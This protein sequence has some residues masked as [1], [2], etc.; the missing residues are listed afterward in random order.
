[1]EAAGP[2]APPV[3]AIMV[4]HQ[5]G[6]WFDDVLDALARQD[7]SNLKVLVLLVGETLDIPAR[8]RDRVPNSFVRAVG[9]NP[10]FGAA[11]NEVLRLVEGDN[12]FFCFLHDDVALD[13]GAIRLL[14]EELYRSNAGVVGPKLVSWDDPRILQHVGLAVDRL[15]EVDPI[16][17]PGEYDQEQHDAVRDVF[18]LPTACLLV[19]ADLFRSIGGFDPVI[20]YQGDDVD[21]CWRAHL[22]GARVMVVPAARG[23]HVEAL[24]IRRP[25]LAVAGPAARNR[26]RTVA[27]LTGAGRLPLIL[28]QL[29]LMTIFHA[30]FDLVRGR[31]RHAVASLVALVGMVPSAPAAL[32]RRRS[33]A[34]IRHVP[35]REVAGLQ[36]R[37]SARVATYLRARDS[38]PEDPEVGNERSWR[39]SAGS[40]PVVVWGLVVLLFLVGSRRVITGGVPRFGEFLPF[41]SSPRDLLGDYLSGWSA[42]GLGSTAAVPTALGLTALASVLTIFHMGLL[43]T[44][45]V[46]GLLVAGYLG[47]W[48]LAT[49]FP[50]ARARVVVL[51]VY[52]AVPLPSQVLAAGRWSALVC[53]GLTPWLV[54]LLRRLGGLDT[55]LGEFDDEREPT[56]LVPRRKVVRLLAQLSLVATVGIAFAPSFLVVFLGI[57]AVLAISTVAGGGSLR[58][59]AAMV[60]ATLAAFAVALVVNLP[61]TLAFA[62]REG[63]TAVVGV[64]PSPSR[65]AGLQLLAR[66]SLSGVRL[67]ALALVLYLPVFAAPLVARSW[68]FTWAVRAAGF[69]TVFGVLAVL[70]DRG[71]LPLRMPEP[72]VLLVPVAVGIAIAAGCIIASFDVDVLAGTFGWRQP[73]AVLSM[74][75]L[76]VGVVPGTLAVANGRWNMPTRTLSSVLN[77][78]P[79]DPATGDY[80][81]L[82][83]GDPRAIPVGS[84]TY[85]KGVGYAVTDD[86]QPTLRER[87]VGI[88]SSDEQQVA[89]AVRQI[90]GGFTLRGGR[91]LAQF[92]I[93]FVVVPLADGVNGTVDKPLEAPKGLSDV[94]DDQLDLASPLTRP[95]NFLVY[96]N[97]AYTPTRSVLTPAGAEASKQAGGEVVAQSDLRGATPWAVG[98]P[99]RGDATGPLP[100]GTL[101][102]AVP[103]DSHWKLTV[104]GRNVPGRRAFGAT[105]AFDVPVAGN[106][107]LTYET[108]PLRLGIVALQ[109]LALVALA[110]A[111]SRVRSSNLVPRRRIAA[112]GDVEP[113]EDLTTVFGP[114]SL[115]STDVPDPLHFIGNP[116]QDAP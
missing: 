3:V 66:M 30:A 45:A 10:G 7:Y 12:G 73:L 111:G 37:G 67:G 51:V 8:V 83:I 35:D 94:L 25:D 86:G 59:A 91:L 104:N 48:R 28:L 20:E 98:S 71:A 87:F 115:P 27:T 74:V 15:G 6:D 116:E 79:T 17:E 55:R 23:R 11:A 70:D 114:P 52:A 39:Q 9:G 18:A 72:G 53:Y 26:M 21:L 84:W 56:R 78:F 34:A 106:G 42:H 85:A 32:L 107:R 41:A 97:T 64:A 93:R 89:D 54:H 29:T 49:I 113:V 112:I 96:E 105:L 1:V 90:A 76:A 108:N 14:V 16:V 22:S 99:D 46:L 50:T 88:P 62:G 31:F 58:A 38:R 95:P 101:H 82:W 2:F 65:G 102:V 68:R 92:G 63:W 57:G 40:A 109:L 110:F 77:Q 69:V 60:G 100:A 36:L 33:I 103:F 24:A 61:W 43:H 80:R 81:I 13:P 4:V 5:P 19:R 75:A 47:A 44:V